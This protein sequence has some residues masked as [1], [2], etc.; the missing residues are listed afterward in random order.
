MKNK[1]L[2]ILS[3]IQNCSS[4]FV[5]SMVEDASYI[6]A[7]DGGQDHA[8]KYGLSPNLVIGDFDST[9]EKDF[10]IFDC[11]YITYPCEKDLTDTEACVEK[12]IELGFKDVV[13]LG[14]IGGRLDHTLGNI[15][16]LSEFYERLDS[17]VFA[18][19]MN[20]MSLFINTTVHVPKNN[21][22]YFALVSLDEYASGISIKGAK[23][24]LDNYT[25]PRGTTLGISNEVVDDYAT[26]SVTDG[27]V[28]LIRS[29]D[30]TK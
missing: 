1:C 25:L 28:L 3:Y 6:I 14:G 8:Q 29:T 21:Y 26:V 2:I 13:V 16:I 11:E 27:K 5:E 15:G 12:A 19:E 7:A 18:D 22:T 24:N 30:F 4:D 17:L 20:E 10:R 23:Y 9:S